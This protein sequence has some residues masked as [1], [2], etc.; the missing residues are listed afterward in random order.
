MVSFLF[1]SNLTINSLQVFRSSIDA[2]YLPLMQD[3]LVSSLSNFLGLPEAKSI[4][5]L[6]VIFISASV[7]IHLLKTF[8]HLL[9]IGQ[10]LPPAITPRM[11]HMFAVASKNFYD[12]L[13]KSQKPLLL[14]SFATT[15]HTVIREVGKRLD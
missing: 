5:C 3:W 14:N 13:S 6:T 7:N 10:R 11:I 2:D 4:W 15:K 8:P 1:N 12:K 9:L